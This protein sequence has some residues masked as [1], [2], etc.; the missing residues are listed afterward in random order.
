[1]SGGVV[2]NSTSSY[3][4]SVVL[5]SRLGESRLLLAGGYGGGIRENVQAP[6]VLI[7]GRLRG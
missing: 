6:G 7:G 4:H 2:F 5:C 3:Y 1:M